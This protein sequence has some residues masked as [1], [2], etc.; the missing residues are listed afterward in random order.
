[1]IRLLSDEFPSANQAGEHVMMY[2]DIVQSQSINL[3]LM[4]EVVKI[5]CR[6]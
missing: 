3:V 5:N 6:S 2:T 1:M 4:L